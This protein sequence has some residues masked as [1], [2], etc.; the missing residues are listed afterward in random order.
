MGETASVVEQV[1]FQVQ[2]SLGLLLLQHSGGLLQLPAEYNVEGLRDLLLGSGVSE[3]AEQLSILTE[4]NHG[5]LLEHLISQAVPCMLTE[6]GGFTLEHH[7]SSQ[8]KIVKISTSWTLETPEAE[9]KFLIPPLSRK[10]SDTIAL[11]V[12]S[13]ICEV[14]PL[15][16][17]GLCDPEPSR[18]FIGLHGAQDAKTYSPG[19]ILK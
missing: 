2:R 12:S 5:L 18:S 9:A 1:K 13:T 15:R 8:H 11:A 16:K 10:R 7:R 4:D 14:C 3:P 19:M 6:W 17:E